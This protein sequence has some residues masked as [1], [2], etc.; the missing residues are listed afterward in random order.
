[1][2]S[3]VF[4]KELSR[5]IDQLPDFD[6]N[7]SEIGGLISEYDISVDNFI[8]SIIRCDLSIK[9]Y[10]TSGFVSTFLE[11]FGELTFL[12]LKRFLTSVITTGI[13]KSF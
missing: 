7:V 3:C 11:S 12:K 10:I 13:S 2:Y 4:G 5:D 8:D 9:E 6:R 1:M